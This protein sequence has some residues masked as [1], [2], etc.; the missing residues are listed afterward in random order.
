[1]K[2]NKKTASSKAAWANLVLIPVKQHFFC[3]GVLPVAVS[4]VGGVGASEFLHTPAA[5]IGMFLTV[6]PVV[7]FGVMYAEQKYHDYKDRRR[8]KKQSA[9]KQVQHDAQYDLQHCAKENAGGICAHKTLTRKNYLKQSALSYVFYAATYMLFPH[10]HDHSGHKHD[11][12]SHDHPHEHHDGCDHNHGHDHNH[13]H[14][15]EHEQA[16]LRDEDVGASWGHKGFILV[17]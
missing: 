8:A 7:T 4:A 15:H 12:H 11:G 14:E 5:E 16:Y 1:M 2:E 17:Q 9:K 6:P 3:C 10:T 13:N